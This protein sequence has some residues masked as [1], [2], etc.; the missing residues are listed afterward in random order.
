MI[1]AVLEVIEVDEAVAEVLDAVLLEVVEAPPEDE[2]PQEVVGEAVQ[3]P[4]VVR[5]SS[6]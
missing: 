4:R 6:S 5:G 3:V 1:E 2:V